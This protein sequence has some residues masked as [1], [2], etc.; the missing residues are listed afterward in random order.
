MFRNYLK[1]R[2]QFSLYPYQNALLFVSLSEC[3][4]LCIPIR[5]QFSLYPYQNAV[6]FVSL[7]ECSS[8]YIPIRINAVPIISHWGCNRKL[9]IF[10][11]V[12]STVRMF[13]FSFGFRLLQMLV[14][15][16]S[17]HCLKSSFFSYLFCK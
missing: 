17:R 4:S 8:L 7:S 6:L 10:M 3:S 14:N 9:P 13:K 15:F 2:M 12:W 16:K 1:F 5:M 11:F